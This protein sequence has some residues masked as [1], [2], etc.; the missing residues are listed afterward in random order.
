MI[1][2]SQETD[3]YFNLAFENYLINHETGKLLYLW[4]NSPSV[5]IGRYQN[6]YEE[7]NLDAMS[8]DNVKLSRRYSG[9]GAVYHDLGNVCFTIIDDKDKFNIQGNFDMVLKALA[10]LGI[11][12]EISGRN[13]ITVNGL[14]VSG[15][16]FQHTRNKSCHHGTMLL[17]SDLH[18]FDRY[19]SPSRKKL[20]SHSVKSVYSRVGNLG[21]SKDL[22]FSAMENVFSDNSEPVFVN[23]TIL[24]ANEELKSAVDFISSNEWL[25]GITPK[26]T[27]K[28]TL[29]KNNQE[30]EV[31]VQVEKGIIKNV[32]IYTDALDL[33]SVEDIKKDLL[34]RSFKSYISSSEDSSS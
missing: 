31:L 5:I 22:F 12:A 10:G 18:V 13:D 25:Y 24:F 28:F 33:Q 3:I 23:K 34:G 1:Y 17:N 19:L 29:R 21:I 20:Q 30:Y 14:K 9:G 7:C 32:E 4:Q 26:F 11:K 2:I 6:P 8:Q 16:A 27:D 15:S